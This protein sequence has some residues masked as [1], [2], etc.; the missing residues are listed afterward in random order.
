MSSEFDFMT[1]KDLIKRIISREISPVEITMR[2]IYRAEA[3]QPTLNAFSVLTPELA[4]EQARVAES[5]V[6]KGKPLGRL[7][8]LPMSVK[9][10]I[11]VKGLPFTLGSRSMEHNVAAHDAP[12]VERLRAAGAIIIGKTTTSEFGCKPVGDSPLSGITRNPWNLDCSP[13]GSS[14]G[15]AASVAAGVTSMALG[16]DGGGSLRIPASLTGCVGFKPTFG[17]VPVWPVS[18]TPTLAHV[19]PLTRNVHDAALMAEVITGYDERDPHSVGVTSPSLI[20]ALSSPLRGLRIAYSPTFGYATPDGEVLKHTGRVFDFLKS[21]GAQV[22]YV[23]EVFEEDPRDIW[24]NEFYAGVSTRLRNTLEHQEELLDPAVAAE[25]KRAS[26]LSM[27]E[28]YKSVFRRYELRDRMRLFF[29]KYDVLLSPTLPVS[30]V[31]AGCNIPPGMHGRG[32]LDWVYYTY[33]FNLTGHPALSLCAGISTNNMPVG[34]QVTGRSLYE[35]HVITV[36][37]VIE[38]SFPDN[39]NLKSNL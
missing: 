38:N 15:A 4:L 20:S 23:E 3:T 9:D 39:Y 24:I 36:A 21:V 19:G 25:L 1:A 29:E 28:Y 2:A 12:S 31:P 34:I 8:G 6:M 32:L 13:G 37:S 22:E 16:T 14:A 5:A 10:L 27:R 35:H 30:A 18:A 33:P 26:N 17:R 11:A 7:H